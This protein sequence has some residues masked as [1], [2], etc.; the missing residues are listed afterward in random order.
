[1]RPPSNFW[2]SLIA[3]LGVVVL[4]GL[5]TW[6]LQR[7]QWK[8]AL[9]AERQAAIRAAPVAFPADPATAAT[10]A[11]HRVSV[12]GTF[13]NDREFHVLATAQ[14]G[15]AG[16]H[17]VTPLHRADGSYV[18]I[19]RGFVPSDRKEPSTRVAGERQGDVAVTGVLRPAQGKSSW[20][21]PDNRPGT[22]EWF[23]VDVPAMA[24]AAGLTPVAPFYVEA[25]ATPNPGGY[26]IGG[27]TVIDLP[28]NHFQYALTWYALAAGLASIY[29]IYMRQRRAGDRI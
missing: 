18:L 26:P 13:L 19:D 3:G 6:Q 23:Y 9:I 14:D 1:M 27:Q 5:G 7:L 8:N 10:L 17:V 25:D 12:A 21:V 11:F 24:A 20:F 2:P 29:I 15:T 22:N 28:N 16:V 4:L